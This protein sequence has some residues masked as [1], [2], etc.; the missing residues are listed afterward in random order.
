ML[1]RNPSENQFVEGPCDDEIGYCNKPIKEYA[2]C[3]VTSRW[4][5]SQEEKSVTTSDSKQN[6]IRS[7]F[8]CTTTIVFKRESGEGRGWTWE[9]E[10]VAKK[11]GIFN[12]VAFVFTKKCLFTYLGC[13]L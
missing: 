4:G 7:V 11:V 12:G 5:L 1:G 2:A 8:L 13:I 10:R 3:M 9:S 6:Q